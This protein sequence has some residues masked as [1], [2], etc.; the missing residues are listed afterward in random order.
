MSEIV[1]KGIDGAN[2]LGF[3]AALG[4]VV[5]LAVH[6]ATVCLEWRIEQGAWRPIVSGVNCDEG[7]FIEKIIRALANS[8]SEP[9]EYEN[10]LPFSADRFAEILKGV[11][12]NTTP[13]K[14]RSADLLA[15]F[16][17]EACVEKDVFKDTLLRMVRSG[18][19]A[20]QGLPYYAR[21][22]RQT[23][24][25][26]SIRR[27][28][29][30]FWDYTDH[31]Y[32]LRWGPL[33]DQRYALRWHDPSKNK[34]EYATGTMNGANAL[35]LESLALFPT[36][37]VGNDLATTG[38]FKDQMKRIYFTWPIWDVAV[39]LD[40]IRSLLALRDLHIEKPPREKLLSYG[41]VEIY[42]CERIAPNKYYRN[43]SM[44]VS[45]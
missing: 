33:E 3:L 6:D 2:P 5:L 14:R 41:I 27:T 12:E 19:A 39:S 8:S 18:D 34:D 23:I 20:G 42:R 36:A 26:A 17:S 13:E 43:F 10:K 21:S 44:A 9:F 32:S 37:L 24:E 25:E 30:D 7:G 4:T 11:V 40:T 35:A 15:A 38:F 31:G 45:V 28:L 1:L 16:G 29:F 22:I